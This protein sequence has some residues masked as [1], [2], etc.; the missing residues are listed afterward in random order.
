M[1]REN[2]VKQIAYHIWEEQG[3]PDGRDLEHWLKAE[4]VWQEKQRPAGPSLQ[5][6][7]VAQKTAGAVQVKDARTQMQ[8]RPPAG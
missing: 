8:P 7:V 1:Q 6:T 3:H 5:H 2:E 4:V